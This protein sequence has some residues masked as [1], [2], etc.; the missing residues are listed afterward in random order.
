MLVSGLH[1]INRRYSF[2]LQKLSNN[3]VIM[4]VL[5][6]VVVNVLI[7]SLFSFV[8]FPNH[9]AGPKIDSLI[10]HFFIAVILSPL[11]E[12]ALVQYLVINFIINKIKNSSLLACIVSSVI[13]AAFHH[14][15]FA[16]VLK[17]FLSG[18]LYGTL[19]LTT[20]QKNSNAFLV[21]SI[22]HSIFNTVGFCIT[23]L[24]RSWN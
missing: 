8:L 5:L 3:S 6:A 22:A 18:F 2:L 13:F 19:Y 20:I 16:Y 23:L 11:V 17:T 9:S 12:T 10:E 4:L 1:T 7:T 24:L 15:S 14:Y 21:T